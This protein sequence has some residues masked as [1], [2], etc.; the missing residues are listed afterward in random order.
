MKLLAL[1][2]GDVWTGIAISD[3][4]GITARPY[5]TLSQTN[6]LS[7]LK[8][9]IE[10]EK[11]EKII[12]GYPET[13]RGTESQQTKKVLLAKASIELDLN[14]ECILVDERWTSKEANRIKK[15]KN[16]R[17]KHDQHAIAAALILTTFLD[18]Q[19]FSEQNNNDD[20]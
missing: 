2:I 3:P 11:I 4:F 5:K 15:P 17:D 18:N 1:D 13:L 8:T 20:S 19:Y 10:Q 14:I 12:I 7:D 9:I 6:F 16:N